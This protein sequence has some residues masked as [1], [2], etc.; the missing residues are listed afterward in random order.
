MKKLK[1]AAL[2]TA[3]LLFLT[4]C[5]SGSIRES[6]TERILPYVTVAIPTEDEKTESAAKA[7]I[8][9]PET[10]EAHTVPETSSLPAEGTSPAAA[11]SSSVPEQTWPAQAE[12]QPSAD[13]GISSAAAA[14]PSAA[15]TVPIPETHRVFCYGDSNTYGYDPERDGGRYPEAVRWTTVLGGLL[16]EGY[17]VIPE[18]KNGR[19]TAFDRPG[20]PEKNGLRTLPELWSAAAPADYLILML[21]TNDCLPEMSLSPEEI[22]S[23]LDRLLCLI[24]ESAVSVQGYPPVV[25]T[26]VPAPIGEHFEGTHFAYELDSTAVEKSRAIAPLYRQ[27]AEAHGSLFLDGT[28]PALGL[29]ISPADCEHLTPEGHRKLAEALAALILRH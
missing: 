15:G 1:Y 26:V 24:E 16:G 22:A 25:I 8:T 20:A 7:R 17:A 18:G 27:I 11:E 23:G 13:P 28:D 21:G 9:E 29:E 6:N 2:F 4:G 19:T 14:E 12:T 10:S 5:A 3:V